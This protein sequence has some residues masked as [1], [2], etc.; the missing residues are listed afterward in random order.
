[1]S[2]VKEMQQPTMNNEVFNHDAETAAK[3][4]GLTE[5]MDLQCELDKVLDKY[6]NEHGKASVIVEDLISN[7]SKKGL[8]LLLMN[9][10]MSL[11]P[12]E[13]NGE[14]ETSGE[15]PTIDND[16]FNHDA[17][18]LADAT[19]VTG[20]DLDVIKG[21]IAKGANDGEGGINIVGIAEALYKVENKK[22]LA[23]FAAAT[24]IE[25]FQA[26]MENDPIM[27]ILS[28]MARGKR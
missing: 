23:T 10:V 1:M 14:K 25:A 15:K 5:D 17:E 16:I 22:V 28:A 11:A 18:N 7:F 9:E 6:H 3:A 20:N 4:I 2:E 26:S 8:A 24:V 12:V 13:E 21:N 19:G 27:A